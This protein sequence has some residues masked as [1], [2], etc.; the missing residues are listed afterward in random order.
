MITTAKEM[1]EAAARVAEGF[2]CCHVPDEIASAI[3]AIPAGD[4]A[5]DFV[6]VQPNAHM[7]EAAAAKAYYAKL[8]EAARVGALVDA[9]SAMCLEFRQLDPPYGSAAY[10]KATNVLAAISVEPSVEAKAYVGVS[11]F[12]ETLRNIAVMGTSGN[13]A[14]SDRIAKT[15]VEEAQK[16]LRQYDAE[17]GRGEE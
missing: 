5:D 10:A 6:E 2:G 8:D 14:V 1:R 17:Y 3:R 11:A 15:A 9:L 13:S 7:W 16:V 12:R 4:K